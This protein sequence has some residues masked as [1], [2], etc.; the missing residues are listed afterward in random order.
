MR[1]AIFFDGKSFYSG[2]VDAIG[3]QPLDF[4]KLA[5]WMVERIGGDLFWGAYY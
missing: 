5:R 3:R 2:M 1:V 4:P